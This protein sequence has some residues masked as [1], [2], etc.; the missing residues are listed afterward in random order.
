[1]F[2]RI[3]SGF[4]I[5]SSRAPI[6]AF[7]LPVAGTCRVTT[8]ASRSSVSSSR[9][10]APS[11]CS[12]SGPGRYAS[13]YTI[14]MSKPR[15]RFATSRPMR[16][17]PTIPMVLP[18]S[19]NTPSCMSVTFANSPRANALCPWVSRR[20]AAPAIKIVHSATVCASAPE[21]ATVATGTAPVD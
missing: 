6:N 13:W 1:M 9:Y 10:S 12:T 15:A 17:R 7:V 8:S 18:A 16:P 11:S 14:F 2:T 19:S 21:D 4:I 20:D 3:A 5:S